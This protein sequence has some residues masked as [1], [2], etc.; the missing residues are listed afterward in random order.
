MICETEGGSS[1]RMAVIV[2]AEVGL[3]NARLPV[4]QL[5]E[6]RSECEQIGTV[7][8]RLT[9][10]LFRRHIADGAEDNS[11]FR[12]VGHRGRS[13]IGSARMLDQLCQTK[14]E[15]LDSSIFGQEQVLRLQ[16]A[17][18]NAFLMC[19]RQAARG[20]DGIINRLPNRQRAA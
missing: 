13:R 17:M 20:L 11:G 3:W 4:K 8:G 9:S 1:L 14:V 12:A 6:N 7:I 16:V 15:N 18:D 5:V 2:S 10:D 19:R